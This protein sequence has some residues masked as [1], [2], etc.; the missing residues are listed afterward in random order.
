MSLKLT[1]LPKIGVRKGFH[2][3]LFSI[4]STE[5]IS[6]AI[7]PKPLKVACPSW[8][9]S[10]FVLSVESVILICPKL[11]KESSAVSIC[12]VMLTDCDSDCTNSKVF[13]MNCVSFS[14][15]VHSCKKKKDLRL[16]NL[17]HKDYYQEK[18]HLERY[19]TFF[20]SNFLFSKGIYVN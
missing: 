3:I 12:S 1:Y 8:V 17:Y 20:W 11:C 10:I 2:C 19:T 16:N 13:C 7:F 6:F 9:T 14:V 4:L 5:R 18:S 15:V